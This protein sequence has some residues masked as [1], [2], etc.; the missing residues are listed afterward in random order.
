M[1]SIATNP[2]LARRLTA[3]GP[4]LFWRDRRGGG[5]EG[6][7]VIVHPCELDP[8]ELLTAGGWRVDISV[9]LLTESA[10]TVEL[11]GE[12]VRV[13]D[14]EG[15]SESPERAFRASIDMP[16]VTLVADP[17]ADPELVF[18]VDEEL[19][20]ELLMVVDAA[21]E[22]GMERA[23]A[24]LRKEAAPARRLV[25]RNQPCPCGSGKKFKRCCLRLLSA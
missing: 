8:A 11:D 14:R 10:V 3:D 17:G 16:E 5:K 6:L 20:G 12:T 21:L 25:G 23:E 24:V 15:R 7:L 13:I 4:V 18:W 1:I 22:R 2:N 19:D 9:Y